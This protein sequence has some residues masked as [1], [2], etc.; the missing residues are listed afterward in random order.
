MNEAHSS[1]IAQIFW[2]GFRRKVICYERQAREHGVSAWTFKKKLNYMMDSIFS[3]TD[4]PIK[5]LV[6]FGSLATLAA[7]LFSVILIFSKLLGL[8]AVPGYVMTLLAIMFFGSL[9]LFSLGLVG[10]YCWRTYE[11]TKARQLS[12]VLK[13]LKFNQKDEA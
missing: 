1:L 2:L 8:I 13:E 7:L 11:N 10:S 9:N 3:F 12:I 5:L 4:L 6:S